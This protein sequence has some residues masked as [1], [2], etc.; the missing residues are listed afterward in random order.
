MH[1]TKSVK[2]SSRGV[3]GC[4]WSG[5]APSATFCLIRLICLSLSSQLEAYGSLGLVFWR[6]RIIDANWKH[7]QYSFQFSYFSRLSILYSKINYTKGV[8]MGT[9]NLTLLKLGIFYKTASFCCC[10]CHHH[11]KKQGIIVS[12][13]TSAWTAI[14]LTSIAKWLSEMIFVSVCPIISSM[15]TTRNK[16]YSGHRQ[17]KTITY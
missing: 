12:V 3:W 5:F 4:F 11:F 13:L 16:S 1:Y 10:C 9:F 6:C 14:C 8:A 15:S 2:S 7:T 17:I